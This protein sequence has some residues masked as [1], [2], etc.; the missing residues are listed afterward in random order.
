[1]GLSLIQKSPTECGV[2]KAGITLATLLAPRQQVQAP[3][4]EQ[5]RSKIAM[6]IRH[7]NEKAG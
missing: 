4:S 3:F 6:P 1:M 7:R 5:T 2:S